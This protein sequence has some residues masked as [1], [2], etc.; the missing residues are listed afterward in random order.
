MLR[1]SKKYFC[2]IGK[3]ISFGFVNQEVC[4]VRKSYAKVFEEFN[5]KLRY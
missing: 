1:N 5:S 4:R 3:A 2:F